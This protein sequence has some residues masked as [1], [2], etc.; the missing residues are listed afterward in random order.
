[1]GRAG[2]DGEPAR[3]VLHYRPEDLALRKFFA[4]GVPKRADLTAFWAVLADT[5]LVD[6]AAEAAG[7]SK[8]RGTALANLYVEAGL[9]RF[10]DGAPVVLE[11]GIDP[12]AAAERA[13][14]AAD[15][16][17]RIDESRIAMIRAYAETTQCR[18]QYLLAYFGDEAAEPCGNCDT[19]D[20][21]AA[22]HWLEQR[23][24]AEGADPFP[25]DTR[26]THAQWG[27]G[28]VMSTE[29]DRITVFFAAEGYR[30]LSL[31]AVEEH[32]LLTRTEPS[33]D[34]Q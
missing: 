6:G 27:E 13:R 11:P 18:R 33:T 29:E 20:S 4:S 28:T 9:L 2:R 8:R 25:V 30:V 14:E 31:A 5:G 32:A 1:M 16:R 21:G 26:V 34:A 10:E 12:A 15:S 3:A 22:E 17:Q 23:G 19:C 24:P 7:V